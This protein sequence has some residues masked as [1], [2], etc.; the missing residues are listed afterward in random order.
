MFQHL[1]IQRTDSS[2]SLQAFFC[3]HLQNDGS[4]KVLIRARGEIAP[5]GSLENYFPSCSYMFYRPVLTSY[6]PLMVQLCRSLF[7]TISDPVTYWLYHLPLN[8]FEF[9]PVVY[10]L[11]M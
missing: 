1:L 6:R 11:K 2:L 10:Q 8:S 3:W 5:I 7:R 4:D 9:Y